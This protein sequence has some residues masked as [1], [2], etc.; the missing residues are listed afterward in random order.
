MNVGM[1]IALAGLL[2]CALLMIVLS[3]A[4]AAHPRRPARSRE[5]VIEAPAPPPEP[6]HG[7]HGPMPVVVPS[8][9][10]LPPDDDGGGGNFWLTQA[11]IARQGFGP[12]GVV[13]RSLYYTDPSDD[14]VPPQ[15]LLATATSSSTEPPGRFIQ[16]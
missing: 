11:R 12:S 13:P 8:P 5:P 9:A 10:E 15:D 3:F 2:A 1:V 14:F 7:V 6:E 4:E 16:G